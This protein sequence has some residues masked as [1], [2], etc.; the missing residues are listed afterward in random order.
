M[1][2]TKCLTHGKKAGPGPAGV[3]TGKRMTKSRETNVPEE[4]GGP[5]GG[6]RARGDGGW[7]RS[8]IPRARELRSDGGQQARLSLQAPWEVG[9]GG[10]LARGPAPPEVWPE[11]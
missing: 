9:A 1:I 4:R 6:G 2:G 5:G 11:T 7:K 10:E 3:R 8:P